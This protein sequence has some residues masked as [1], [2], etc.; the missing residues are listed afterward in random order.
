[1]RTTIYR[2]QGMTCEHCA[3]AVSREVSTLSAVSDVQVDVAS[4]N[5][6]ITSREVLNDDSVRVA[7]EEAG[8]RLHRDNQLPMA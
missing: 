8:Y 7:V 1:M 3:A 5:L 4:G 2:V 6:L